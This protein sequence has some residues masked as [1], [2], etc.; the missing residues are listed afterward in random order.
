MGEENI[1]KKVCKELGIT[2]KELAERIGVNEGTPAQWSSKG[3]IPE[4]AKKFMECLLEKKACED[5]LQK[6]QTAFKLIDE[7]KK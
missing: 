2:Q 5:K 3:N 4:W 7:A 1:V 6:F